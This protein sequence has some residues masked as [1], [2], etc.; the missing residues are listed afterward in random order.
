VQYAD[1]PGRPDSG[2]AGGG[3]GALGAHNADIRRGPSNA[4][5]AY[6]TNA[7]SDGSED[8]HIAHSPPGNQYLDDGNPYYNDIHNPQGP[9]GDHTY[10]AAPPVIRDVQARRNTRIENAGIYPQQGNAGIAQNF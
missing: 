5:S 4:S 10:G 7:R 2:E 3:I 9:Y 1:G 6:S 8:G